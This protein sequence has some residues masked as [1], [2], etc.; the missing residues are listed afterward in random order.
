MEIK[1][2]IV[3]YGKSI[4]ESETIKSLNLLDGVS[5]NIDLVIWNNGPAP[6]DFDVETLI[7]NATFIETLDNKP[8][9]IIYN[10]F[11]NSF[12]AERYVILDDD[13][14]I[15]QLYINKIID[16]NFDMQIPII[17]CEETGMHY[18]PK[19]NGGAF[20]GEFKKSDTI[21]A[22]GSGLC[23]N[24]NI[25]NKIADYYGDVFDSRF[26]FYGI[27]TTF[28]KRLRKLGLSNRV[29]IISGFKH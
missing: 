7:N 16:S 10:N 17:Y 14:K 25:A 12:D 21:T 8:L 9:S 19:L 15:T 5:K 29:E 6:I 18:S 13:S 27:D 22:I 26:A 23:I 28:F 20:Y 2:L 24:K 4:S 11:I 1:L 3:L